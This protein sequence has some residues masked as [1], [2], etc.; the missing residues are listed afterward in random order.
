[1]K[2][3]FFFI[4]ALSMLI[5]FTTIANANTGTGEDFGKEIFT[6]TLYSKTKKMSFEMSNLNYPI[7]LERSINKKQKYNVFAISY[8]IYPAYDRKGMSFTGIIRDYDSWLGRN[9]DPS[10]GILMNLD[11]TIDSDDE[12]YGL[13]NFDLS[14]TLEIRGTNEFSL[15]PYFGVSFI[16]RIAPNDSDEKDVYKIG[17]NVGFAG[18]LRIGE[19]IVMFQTSGSPT[20]GVAYRVGVGVVI[21]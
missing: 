13:I 12:R 17:P 9:I 15:F 14:A 2:I 8:G 19:T 6:R 5:V 21:K 16:R 10:A 1:M 3:H 20:L 7:I 18:A 11:L 4:V